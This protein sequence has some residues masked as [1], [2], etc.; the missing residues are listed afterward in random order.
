MEI[1]PEAIRKARTIQRLSVSLR[2]GGHGLNAVPGLLRQILTE[3]MWVKFDVEIGGDIIEKDHCPEDFAQFVTDDPPYGLG[4]SIDMLIRIC[5]G[6]VDVIDLI[7]N[8]VQRDRGNLEFDF[9]GNTELINVDNVNI[10][11]SSVNNRPDGNSQQSGLR[12]LR[13][14]IAKAKTEDQRNKVK[15][16]QS[17]VFNNELSVHRALVIIGARKETFTIPVD[18]NGAAKSIKKRFNQ[19]QIAELINLLKED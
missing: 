7:D 12:R 6:H 17:Q 4:S 13:A 14:E 19:D 9:R 3:K 2:E 8:E 16:L 18:P 10:N 1:S 15:K 11:Q 5:A